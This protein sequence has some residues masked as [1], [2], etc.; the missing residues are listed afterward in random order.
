[1]KRFVGVDLASEEKKKTGIVCLNEKAELV[2]KPKYLFRDEEILNY[3]T[4]F[5]PLWVGIDAPLSFPPPGKGYRLCDLTSLRMGV[6]LFPPLFLSSLTRRGMS[7]KKRLTQRGLK[8]IEVYPPLTQFTLSLKVE[9]KKP[10]RRWRESLQRGLL[11]WVR[12]LP[13][14]S[15]L[16]LS[17]HLLDA[18]LCALTA[19]FR[20]EGAYREIGNPREGT[21]VMP[22][23]NLPPRWGK[24]SFSSNR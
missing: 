8:V 7:L 22:S 15:S 13:P 23:F 17:V 21:I 18:L 20:G 16:L 10:T 2:E 6:R 24:R 1:M 3:L 19:Y 12:N 9:G 5:S 4:S 14:P 11:L